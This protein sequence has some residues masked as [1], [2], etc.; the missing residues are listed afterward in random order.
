MKLPKTTVYIGVGVLAVLAYMWYTKK[1]SGKKEAER[2]ASL[3][4]KLVADKMPLS[5]STAPDLAPTALNQT[6]GKLNTK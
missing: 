5:A 3:K 6:A 4:A 2:L 1:Q